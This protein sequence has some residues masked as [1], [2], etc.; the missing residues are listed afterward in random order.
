MLNLEIIPVRTK[1]FRPPQDDIFEAL[2]SLPK[3]KNGDLVFITSKVLAIHQGRCI[4]ISSKVDKH[5]L[6]RKESD[7]YLPK[8]YKNK[9][10]MQLTIKDQ[11]LIPSSGIDESN[12]NDHYIL[13]PTNTDK[14]LKDIHKFLIK[15][16]KI[17]NLGLISTDSHTTPLRRGVSGIATGIYGVE[18]IRDMKGKPDVFKR[19]LKFTQVNLIDPLVG[20]AV[21]TMGEANEQ[22]PILVMRGLKNFKF[23]NRSTYNKISFPLEDD[24]YYPLLKNF[25]Q[26]K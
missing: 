14:L 18:P 19:K 24:L 21:L 25:K 6:A 26:S 9:Y 3:L 20:L 12:G 5:K 1:K 15:R 13:W 7:L 4:P 11:V 10:D 8:K 2:E 17:K 22:T 23:T 16:N